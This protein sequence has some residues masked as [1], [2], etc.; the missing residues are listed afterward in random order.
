MPQNTKRIA[1]A[2]RRKSG[3]RVPPGDTG[4]KDETTIDPTS[5]ASKPHGT[6]KDQIDEMESEGQAQGQGQEP[7]PKANDK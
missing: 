7:P 3:Q 6:T 4:D 5:P 1:T 2:D